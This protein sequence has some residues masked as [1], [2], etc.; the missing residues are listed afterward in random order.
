LKIIL[1]KPQTEKWLRQ[2]KLPVS[3][4]DDLNELD[5]AIDGA[6]EVDAQ[7]TCLLNL[8]FS[9]LLVLLINFRHKRRRRMFVLDNFKWKSK[10]PR[11]SGLLREKVVQS[12]AK[13]FILIGNLEKY[14]EVLGTAYKSCAIEV[15][16]FACAPVIRW[17]TEKAGL[18]LL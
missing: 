2:A 5:L 7:L 16:P 1:P 11:I 15:V 13:R 4:L 6:D 12:C 14:S 9:K 18:F 8:D 17:I 10:N 3:S